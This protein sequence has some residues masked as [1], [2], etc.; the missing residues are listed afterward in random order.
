MFRYLAVR[1]E[2]ELNWED[3]RFIDALE[4]ENNNLQKRITDCKSSIMMVTS[5]DK[6]TTQ[7]W[8]YWRHQD[9]LYCIMM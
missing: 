1:A 8:N 3:P 2:K 7:V 5:F 9:I 6:R 4:V